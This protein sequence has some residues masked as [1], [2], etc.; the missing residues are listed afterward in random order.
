[1]TPGKP[2]PRIG[3]DTAPFWAAA[4]TGKL[5]LPGCASCGRVHW[6]AGPI[7]PF[8]LSDAIAWR[9]AS[10]RGT[11]S[12]FTVIH[13]AWFAA[14]A[15]EVPYNVVQVELEEGPRIITNLVDVPPGGLT[16]G[17]A[18]EVVFDAVTPEVTLPRFRPQRD[19]GPSVSIGTSSMQ[20]EPAK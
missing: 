14:F 13:K 12:T 3:P 4:R 11:V 20:Q 17:L 18:V 7:C 2:L 6:P 10:G 8:C 9:D 15:E 19:C 1:M 5:R 16:I